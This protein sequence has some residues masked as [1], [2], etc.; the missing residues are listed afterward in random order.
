M[1]TPIE[2]EEFELR[3]VSQLF[4]EDDQQLDSSSGTSG[5]AQSSYCSCSA[6]DRAGPVTE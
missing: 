6:P 4:P 5:T 3:K 1:G 2:D